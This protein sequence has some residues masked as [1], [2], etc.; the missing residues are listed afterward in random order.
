M[1][2]SDLFK[3]YNKARAAARQGRLD[4][5]RVNTALGALQ[6]GRADAHWR[7]YG[8]TVSECNCPDSFYRGTVCYGRVALMIVTR[9]KQTRDSAPVLQPTG[10]RMFKS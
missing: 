7:K 2:R 5:D 9:N 8:T 3:W 4:P 1:N 10:S 6:S